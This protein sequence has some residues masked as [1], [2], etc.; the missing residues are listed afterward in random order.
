MA[1]QKLLH[2]MWFF[3]CLSE[4]GSKRKLSFGRLLLS[5]SV[6]VRKTLLQ[7]HARN[8]RLKFP[9]VWR[10]VQSLN[11]PFFPPHIGAE[12]G[13]A[14][15]ESRITCMRM[16]RTPPFFPPKSGEKPYLVVFSRFGLWRD[17]L[18]DNIKATISVFRLINNMSM[19]PNQ[20]NFTSTTLNHIRFGFYH[21]IKDNER[22]LC[23]DLLTIENT[24]SGLKVH[25]LHYANELLVRVR[26]SIQKLLQNRSTYRNNTKTMFVDKSADHDEPYFDFYVFMFLRQRQRQRKCFLSE[27]ELKKA[28]RDTLTRA[29][30][31]GSVIFD[32]FVLSMRMQVILDSSFARPGSAPIWNGKK[33]EFRDCTMWRSILSAIAISNNLKTVLQIFTIRTDTKPAN[34]ML[35]FSCSKLVLQPI[36]NGFVYSTL[37][38]NRVARRLLTICKKIFPTN[39]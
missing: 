38:L 27:R 18:N 12:P 16:L 21:N 23:Q 9:S 11:S 14:K 20:W 37:S 1:A 31:L 35:F 8:S 5:N 34:N 26:L 33:G 30:W 7:L 28:L 2:T 13:R 10:L 4:I 36:T 24:D 6:C 22:N 25:A 19:I 3:S 15:E 32:W 29:A 39:E 17:F